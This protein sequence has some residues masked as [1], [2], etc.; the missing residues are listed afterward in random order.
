MKDG[1]GHTTEQL[2]GYRELQALEAQILDWKAALNGSRSSKKWQEWNIELT[3]MQRWRKKM[4][5][6]LYGYTRYP[7]DKV[8]SDGSPPKNLN[9]QIP[10]L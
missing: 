1:T 8:Y 9:E 6:S 2:A 4:L 7:D 5:F 10:D 3:N